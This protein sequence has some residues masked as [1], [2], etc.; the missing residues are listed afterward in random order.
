MDRNTADTALR[1][2]SKGGFWT[3][4]LL[5]AASAALMAL[6]LYMVYFWVPTD[7]N[8]GVS[9]RIFY[10]HVPLAM[11][12]IAALLPVAVGS[13]LYLVKRQ[14]CWDWF[15]Y[16]CA[17]AGLVF[18]TLGLVTGSIWAKPV[19]GQWWTWDPKLTLTAIIW[20]I[21]VAYMMVRAYSPEGSQQA[22]YAS[23]VAIMGVIAST[24][25]YL[26]TSLWRTAHPETNIGPLAQQG[27]AIA[28]SAINLT[29]MTALV[30]FAVLFAAVVAQRYSM[31]ASEAFVDEMYRRVSH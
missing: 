8:L 5:L 26:A 25:N 31:K 24:L 16:S 19:W 3:P 29:L 11:I 1:S 6:T 17:E 22:R 10:F 9:Q 4:D 12:G 18:A 20:F 30:T 15:A 7:L 23:V 2:V 13:V 27:D 21:Y 28:S 14:T